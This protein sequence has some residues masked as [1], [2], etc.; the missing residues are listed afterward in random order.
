MNA[1]THDRKVYLLRQNQ[2]FKTAIQRSANA[3]QVSSASYA[4]SSGVG[5]L[6]RLVPQLTGDAG[7]LKRL[8]II[9]WGSGTPSSPKTSQFLIPDLSKSPSK[10]PISHT[11]DEIQLIRPQTTG[12]TWSNWWSPRGTS[13]PS[14]ESMPAKW[15]VDCLKTSKG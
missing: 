13:A 2:H 6:P 1:Q 12:G 9:G 5:L 7:L 4:P 14:G 3:A 10:S 8:S 15:Y 11:S